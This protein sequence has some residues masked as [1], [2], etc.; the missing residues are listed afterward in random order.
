MQFEQTWPFLGC[1]HFVHVSVVRTRANM[2]LSWLSAFLAFLRF[3]RLALGDRFGR[4]FV[5]PTIF[6]L[7]AGFLNWR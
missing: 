6:A 7:A 2:T 1:V 5:F 4:F 3:V